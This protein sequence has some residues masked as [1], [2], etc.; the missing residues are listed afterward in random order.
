MNHS[1]QSAPEDPPV[2]PDKSTPPLEV[3]TFPLVTTSTLVVER[4]DAVIAEIGEPHP[5]SHGVTSDNVVSLLRNYL[6]MSQAFPFIQA[7]AHGKVFAESIECSGDVPATVEGAFVVGSFLVWDEVGGN[8]CLSSLGIEGLPEILKTGDRFHS[9]L[10]K[11]D[12][13]KLLKTEAQPFYG[14]I[15]RE[16]L[17]DLAR[18]LESSDHVERCAAMV[19]F[20]HHAHVMIEGLW[21]SL[22]TLFGAEKSELTYFRV[23]VGGDDPAER[24][25]VDMTRR[26][27]DLMVPRESI[28]RFVESFT[29][30]FKSH[31]VWCEAIKSSMAATSRR[32]GL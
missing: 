20:E 29:E 17:K 25:H 21:G 1:A 23:H 28:P 7:G 4:I 27:I 5:F 6:A 31:L 14:D 24:Y 3:T 2:V 16:Y 19:A 11:N 8:Y 18:Q 13:K 9:N 26:L 12:M 32:E 10:L 22:T 15:T 30:C